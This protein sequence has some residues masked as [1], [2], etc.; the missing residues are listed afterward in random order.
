[1]RLRVW[2]ANALMCGVFVRYVI[3]LEWKKVR[4]RFRVEMSF[5]GIEG[6]KFDGGSVVL[7]WVWWPL[8]WREDELIYLFCYVVR[9]MQISKSHLSRGTS[10]RY[11]MLILGQNPKTEWKSRKRQLIVELY[12]NIG[13]RK[14]RWISILNSSIGV[15]SASRDR[16]EPPAVGR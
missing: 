12:S 5:V 11:R 10:S 4:G 13:S 14:H 6:N 3:W 9:V 16:L 7:A 8:C 15:E 1:M 2:Y